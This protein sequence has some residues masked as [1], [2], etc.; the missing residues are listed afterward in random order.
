MRRFISWVLALLCAVAFAFAGGPAIATTPS[1]HAYTIV[2][3]CSVATPGTRECFAEKQ[4]PTG[5][6]PATVT[7][8]AVPY[9]FGP[10]D[11][12]SAYRIPASG[13]SGVTVG[14][15]DA[16]DDPTAEADLGTYRSTYGL[17]ACT[18]ANGC[19]T[20]V[21]QTGSTTALPSLDTGWAAEIA[22]D[23][24]MVS[25][26]CPSCH[27][28]L[29]EATSARNSDLDTA[30][31]YAA[32]HATIVSNSYGGSESNTDTGDDA[33]FNHAGVT[34][35]ASS[36]DEGYA[37][38][39]PAA[40][41]TVIGV[42]GTA[43]TR[44]TSTTRGWTEKVWD[45]D[46][47]ESTGSG[48]SAYET[49]PSW[50]HDTGCTKRTVADVSAVAD[51]ATG[52]SVYDSTGGTGWGIYGGTSAAAPLVGAILAV[53]GHA[54]VS[55]SYLYAHPGF[56]N[57]VTAGQTASSC[58]SYL[59]E[60]GTGYD[61]PTG[62]GTPI[63]TSLVPSTLPVVTT[64]PQSQTAPA[65]STVTLTA[66]AT[67]TPTPTV[68]WQSSTNHGTTW[69]TIPGRTTTTLTLANR[70]TSQSGFQ[71]RAVFTNTGGTTPTN[72]A[73]ITVIAMAANAA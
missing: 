26:G 3:L 48:C 9:G 56:F 35:L 14:I 12:A 30:V 41:P 55:A 37:V 18:T 2:H 29:V 60:A 59:C 13:G 16:Y 70:Q 50:Q 65:G 52:V 67:G 33:H 42:G 4:V 5:P 25:A 62:L 72:P 17:P 63:G 58:T 40:S 11:L 34:M 8:D 21:S 51:P 45:T 24:E 19:F 61:G 44:D 6:A 15:V 57:D 20:K 47:N 7:P 53:T 69:T 38:E 1:S 22:L 43:L 66:A 23:I 36:G 64:Q 73:T 46:N 71:Y 49:K 32:A 10:G 27:I 54:G 39:F 68:T 31:D 28:L